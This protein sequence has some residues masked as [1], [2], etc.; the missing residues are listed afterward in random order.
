MP[1]KK[2]ISGGSDGSAGFIT[3]GT[4][5]LVS[6]AHPNPDN[7]SEDVKE[8]LDS[9]K[10]EDMLSS[11]GAQKLIQSAVRGAM[12]AILS[13]LSSKA[14]TG[15]VQSISSPGIAAHIS[16]ANDTLGTSIPQVDP[17][18]ATVNVTT[19]R[20]PSSPTS[21]T[22]SD[23][24]AMDVVNTPVIQQTVYTNAPMKQVDTTVVADGVEA[25]NDY[26]NAMEP[27]NIPLSVPNYHK[28]EG[29]TT[30]ICATCKYFNKKTDQTGDCFAYGFT[31]ISD[32][33]CDSWAVGMPA[34]NGVDSDRTRD[35]EN[36]IGQP[37][38]N[39]VA[40]K[41]RNIDFYPNQIM[42]QNSAAAIEAR[43]HPA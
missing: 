6:Q 25:D 43:E 26:A 21:I 39:D 30:K 31:A 1:N 24:P 19:S 7:Q 16:A 9:Q 27:A 33:T 11:E 18:L 23:I 13:S 34:T 12:E 40:P 37:V 3:G 35:I 42:A 20:Q 28:P 36:P 14:T 10:A 32:H 4:G 15:S 8:I 41:Y 17:T 5:E 38:P 29:P 2:T 22:T